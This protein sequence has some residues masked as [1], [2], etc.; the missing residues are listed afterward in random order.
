MGGGSQSRR[1]LPQGFS[2]KATNGGSGQALAATF[3]AE[4]N[5]RESATKAFRGIFGLAGS[6]FDSPPQL[7]SAVA[8]AQDKQVQA[9]FRAVWN[10]AR[11]R[12]LMVL[13]VENGR[14]YSGLMFDREDLFGRSLSGMSRPDAQVRKWLHGS[15]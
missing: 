13:T 2:I 10:G 9:F 12:G 11:V 7:V 5:G 15:L 4:F 8:D 3:S 1:Q 6:Y 14:G